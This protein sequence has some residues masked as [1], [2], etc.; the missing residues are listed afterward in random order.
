MSCVTS[1]EPSVPETN[2]GVAR[3]VAELPKV[4]VK[5]AIFVGKIE[6][7]PSPAMDAPATIVQK[8]FPDTRIITPPVRIIK[9]KKI[10]VLMRKRLEKKGAMPR[11]AMKKKK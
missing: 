1:A 10:I 9:L 6:E 2:N 7:V 3:L 8:L 11:P 4:S 5:R